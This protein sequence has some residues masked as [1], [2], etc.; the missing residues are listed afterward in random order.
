MFVIL[1][2]ERSR[3]SL[4]SG[5]MEPEPIDAT[6]CVRQERIASRRIVREKIQYEHTD[7]SESPAIYLSVDS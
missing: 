4:F 6:G 3:A 7:W 1:I 5:L 2:E